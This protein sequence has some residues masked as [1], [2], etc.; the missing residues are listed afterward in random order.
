MPLQIMPRTLVR[1]LR[2]VVTIH[3]TSG[4]VPASV[5]CGACSPTVW[6]LQPLSPENQLME[7]YNPAHVTL[8]EGCRTSGQIQ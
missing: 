1:S 6:S 8:K 5:A 4:P 2:Y 7:K 3:T